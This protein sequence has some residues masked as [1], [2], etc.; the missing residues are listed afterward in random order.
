MNVSDFLHKIVDPSLAFAAGITQIPVTDAARVLV[1]TI[2]G[3]ESDWRERRQIGGPARSYWQFEEGGGVVGLF[4]AVPQKLRAVCDALD[5]PYDTNTVFEAMA[6][7]DTLAC[8]M[9]RLLLWTDSAPLPALHD[10]DGAWAYYLRN[11]RPGAP[12]PAVW[13]GRY[14]QSLAAMGIVT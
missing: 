3:Q 6:W 10:K 13:S 5:I 11:W 4:H 7:N 2:A 1:M 14:D 12:H 9:A 8:S